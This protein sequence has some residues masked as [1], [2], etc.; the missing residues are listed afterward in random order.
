MKLA[1][2]LPWSDSTGTIVFDPQ[3]NPVNNKF[4]SGY[5]HLADIIN[6]FGEVALYVGGFLMFF[7]AIWGV[8]DYL[9]AEGNKEALAKARKRIQWAIAGFIILIMSFFL[10]DVVKTIIN[11]GLPPLTGVTPP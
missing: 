6:A 1:L 3:S 10:S 8:F 9:R 4:P 11:P 5:F 2:T 7:W